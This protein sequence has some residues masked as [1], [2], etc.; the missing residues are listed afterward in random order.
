VVDITVLKTPLAVTFLTQLSTGSAW[1]IDEVPAINRGPKEVAQYRKKLHFLYIMYPQCRL[2]TALVLTLERATETILFAQAFL[3][4]ER[5]NHVCS[6]PNIGPE[7]IQQVLAEG[8]VQN[9]TAALRMRVRAVKGPKSAARRL[10]AGRPTRRVAKQRVRRLATLVGY[11]PTSV[12]GNVRGADGLQ[13]LDGVQI[14]CLSMLTAGTNSVLV[15]TPRRADGNRAA[16]AFGCRS[17][18]REPKPGKFCNN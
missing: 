3:L 10:R 2:V 15:V 1:A 9:L 4:R 6:L 14:A 13:L 7:F 16:A 11:P 12:L 8:M 18:S 17:A 5:E